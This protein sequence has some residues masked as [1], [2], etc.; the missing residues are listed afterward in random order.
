MF[1]AQPLS[2]NAISWCLRD[3]PSWGERREKKKDI[4]GTVFKENNVGNFSG[5]RVSI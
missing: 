3:V 1:Y 5:D 4:L 2:R